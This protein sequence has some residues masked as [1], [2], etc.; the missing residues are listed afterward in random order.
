MSQGDLAKAT[1]LPPSTIAHFE[2]GGRKPSFDNLRKLANALDVT[3]D[4]L[5]GRADS[6]DV[7]Q[8]ADPLY[9]YGSRLTASD[10]VIAEDFLRMLSERDRKHRKRQRSSESTDFRR[11]V[12]V[13][14]AQHLLESEGLLSL[15]VDLTALAKTRDIVIEPMEGSGGGVSGM[16]VRCGNSFGILYDT[17]IRNEGFQRFSVAH[18]LG[19]YFVEGHIDQIAFVGGA[20]RSSAGFISTDPVEREADYFAAGLLMPEAPVQAIIRQEPEGLSAIEAIQRAARSSL[21]ASAIRYVGL[22]DAAAAVIVSRDGSVDYCFMSNAMKSLNPDT[23]PRKGTP[24]PSS[25]ATS[26]IAQFTE[27]ERHAARD[28]V[29]IDAEIWF[30]SVQCKQTREEVIGLGSYGRIL[31]VVTCLDLDEDELFD[32]N[33]SDGAIEKSWTPRLRRR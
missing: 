3:T 22:T 33:D 14:K 2:G 17:S 21:T 7:A 12:L 19:H 11:T 24:L 26:A 20:H 5:L 30:G 13:S 31:T 25:T 23:W 27:G 16:L 9:R 18:E 15:P 8:E 10:R 1:G 6:P 4:F 32:E 28:D 29:E